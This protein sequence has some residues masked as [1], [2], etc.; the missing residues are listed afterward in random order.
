MKYHPKL[1]QYLHYIKLTDK[2][3]KKR[4]KEAE[5]DEECRAN[6]QKGHVFP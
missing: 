3:K 4:I 6:P 1:E 2:E 5:Q